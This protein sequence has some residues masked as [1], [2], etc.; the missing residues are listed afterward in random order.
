MG[1]WFGT[2]L[3]A[4]IRPGRTVH[5]IRLWAYSFIRARRAGQVS[6]GSMVVSHRRCIFLD[7]ELFLAYY[8]DG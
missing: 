8:R 6:E 4:G 3:S 2:C 5:A 1:H 7:A